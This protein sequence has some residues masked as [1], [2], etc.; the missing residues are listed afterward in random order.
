VDTGVGIPLEYQEMIFSPFQQ[1]DGSPT[2][3]R[4]GSGL[5]LSIVRQLAEAMGGTVR[6]ESRPGDGSKFTVVLPIRAAPE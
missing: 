1:V 3:R 4:G 2:R 6:V 5:G